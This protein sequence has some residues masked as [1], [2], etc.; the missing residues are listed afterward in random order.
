VVTALGFGLESAPSPIATATTTYAI[1]DIGPAGGVVFYDKGSNSN[2]W[3]YLEA[4]PGDQSTGIQWFNGSYATTGAT[5]TAIGTGAANTQAIIASQGAGS[6]AAEYCVYFP[7]GGYSDWFL[8]SEGEL[9]QMYV[10]LY[11]QGRGGFASSCYWSSSESDF[12][13]LARIQR[14]D[15]GGHGNGDKSDRY[16]V[17]AAR[18]F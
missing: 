3:R 18:A 15:D 12:Y 14:F 13:G 8:P 4:A 1:G 2:G 10:N 7:L 16:H 5:A 11:Q 17:R 6:Y 9:N